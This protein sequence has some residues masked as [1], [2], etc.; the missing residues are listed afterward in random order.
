MEPIDEWTVAELKGELKELGLSNSGNKEKLYNR[1]L[2]YEEDEEWDED[3][4][5]ERDSG[6]DA[7]ELVASLTGAALRNRVAIAAVLGVA[8]LVVSS[9]WSCRT[10]RP[11]PR[12]MCGSLPSRS[13]TRPM[14][15]PSS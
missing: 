8:M 12:G 2:E 13:E 1:L 15:S 5:D 3:D 7:S 9:I 4:W 11:N 6:F 10:R 14:S